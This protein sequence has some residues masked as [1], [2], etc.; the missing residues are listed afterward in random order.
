MRKFKNLLFALV[1]VLSVV[2][3]SNFVNTNKVAKLSPI[4]KPVYIAEYHI[5]DPPPLPSSIGYQMF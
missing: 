5:I 1:I 3:L 4:T 2:V